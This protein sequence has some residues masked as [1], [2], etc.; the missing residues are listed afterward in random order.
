MNRRTL[1]SLATASMLAA[2]LP[3][4]AATLSPEDR[5]T[6]DQVE[7]Y[8]ESLKTLA[9]NFV[10]VGPEGDV[11]RGEFYLRRPGR[12]RFEYLPPV[13]ILIV[14]DGIWLILNDTELESVDRWPVFDTPLAPLLS[15]KIDLS[16]K[17]A[18]VEVVKVGRSE[19]Q[20]EITL[21]DKSSPDEG[22]LTLTFTTDPITLLRWS[23]LD[24]Q[25]GTT[26]VTL[27]TLLANPDLDPEL[28]TF[29]D[30][31]PFRDN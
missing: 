30:P 24:A 10:Q 16:S 28:F 27:N 8:L 18:S 15:R 26:K 19:G 1:L 6:L 23:V 9:A 13:P 17:S 22:S 5:A 7:S 31:Q 4:R 25:G 2:T 14:A 20:I 29:T 3:A 12:L 11:S 21:I